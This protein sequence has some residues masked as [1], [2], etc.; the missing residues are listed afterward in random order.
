LADVEILDAPPAPLLARTHALK[1]KLAIAAGHQ[2]LAV[3]SFRA[4]LGQFE[5]LGDTRAATEMLANIGVMLCDLGVLEEAERSL[6]AAWQNSE[7]MA[8]A[9]VATAVLVNLALVRARLGRLDEARIAAEEA[10]KRAASQGDWR[11]VGF[12]ELYFSEIA[13]SAGDFAG[14][15]VHARAALEVLK[16]IPPLRPAAHASLARALLARGATSAALIQALEGKSLAESIGQV[17]DGEALIHLALVECLF[18][19]GAHSQG[20]EALTRAAVRLRERAASIDDPT[21]RSA[22]LTRVPEHR[23]VFE[24]M[25]E[26]LANES[27]LPG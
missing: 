21:W 22:F 1:A 27:L 13:L 7:R 16:D 20:E 19:S 4:S 12:A 17:E 6:S 3:E 26:R 24:L 9:Y 2:G 8:L 5:Q 25:K 15:T 11:M 14:A 18:A 23:R 10:R